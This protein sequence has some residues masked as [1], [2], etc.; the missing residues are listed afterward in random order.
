MINPTIIVA[1]ANGVIGA[2]LVAQL[3]R[4]GCRVIGLYRVGAR[5]HRPQPQSARNFYPVEVH[6]FECAILL[7]ALDGLDAGSLVNC[8]GAGVAPDERDSETLWRGNVS[9]VSALMAVAAAKGIERVIHTGSEAEYGRGAAGV[10]I[11]E[12]HPIL[13]YS[14]YGAAKA[15]SVCYATALA[16]SLSVK[17][18]VLRPFYVY[19]FGERSHR[20]LPSIAAAK[21]SGKSVPMSRGEQM[22]DLLYVDD[23]VGAY[24]AAIDGAWHNDVSIYNVCSGKARRIRDVAELAT[25]MFG[26]SP[27]ALK[28]GTLPERE[29]DASWIVGDP[30]RISGALGWRSAM[31]LEQGIESWMRAYYTAQAVAMS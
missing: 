29:T 16:Q 23:A 11:S 9:T 27:D 25:R 7:R 2:A 21:R 19:G 8:V 31:T 10:L 17:L 13:P 4:S 20:L 6:A 30:S 14:E 3:L 12:S 5:W 15:A 22:R 1:G 28:W 24:V 18:V 26:V